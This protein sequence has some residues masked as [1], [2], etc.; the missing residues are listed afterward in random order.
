MYAGPL[1][2]T[3]PHSHHSFQLLVS[4]GEP[5]VLRDARGQGI[6]CK[7]AVTPP[8]VE[9]T[10]AS[11][12]PAVI[13]LHVNP[14]DVVGRQL[15]T[16]G[17]GADAD[18]WRRAGVPL[19]SVPGVTAVPKRWDDSER[20]SHAL[21]QALSADTRQGPP[22]H[23]AVKKLLRLLP[24]LLEEDVRLSALASRVEL[25]EGRL[26]HLFGEEVGLPLRPYIL[27]LRLQRAAAHLQRGESLTQA[28]HAAGFTDSAHLSHAFRRT[29]GMSPSEIAG[30]VDWVLPPPE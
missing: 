7:A 25:S 6:V 12:G 3:R 8:D 24:E 22:A 4:L 21:L 19:C 17:I 10:I 30:V 18:A 15:R 1:G 11:A 27:W 13:I 26:S 29:F 2:E 9:H 23:P 28:A 14:D 5:V 20:V 16:L